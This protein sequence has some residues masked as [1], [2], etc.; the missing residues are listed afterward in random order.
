VSAQPPR[1]G[2]TLVADVGFRAAVAPL[3]EEGL[4]DALEVTVDDRFAHGWSNFVPPRW[5]TQV[6]DLFADA[7]A[8]Y[9][10]GVFFSVLSA[11]FDHERQGR[12][13]RLLAAECKRRKYQH[14]SEHLGYYVA[15]GFWMGTTLPVPHTA[16]SVRLGV[17]R[18]KMLAD[19]AQVPVGLENQAN[20]LSPDDALGQGDFLEAILAP[21]N[22]F[23]VLDVHNV[24]VQAVN[25]GLSP[26]RLLDRYPLHRVRE[27]HISGGAWWKAP[28]GRPVRLDSH[29]GPVP[30]EAFALLREAV[31]RCPHAEVVFLER[32]GATLEREDADEFREDFLRVRRIVEEAHVAR[33]A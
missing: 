25:L 24:Y 26:L 17:E 6:T 30:D 20:M 2:V 21:G 13:L 29:D 8:L 10:H 32:R 23:L 27:L 14:V 7:D 22:G 5:M 11:R 15:E 16:A 4:I 1:V 3:L 31:P 9:G 28:D 33:A 18:M 19:A 12:W